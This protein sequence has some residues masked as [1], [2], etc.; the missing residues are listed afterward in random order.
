MVSFK[1]PL[2]DRDDLVEISERII[3]DTDTVLCS[4]EFYTHLKRGHIH[5]LV[6]TQENKI[7]EQEEPENRFSMQ[8]ALG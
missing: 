7:A 5:L 8:M 1:C 3:R 4:N 6:R 2:C